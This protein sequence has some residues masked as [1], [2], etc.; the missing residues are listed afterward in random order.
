MRVTGDKELVQALRALGKGLPVSAIDSS[1]TAASKPMLDEAVENARAH[2][3]SG[4]RP[5]GG[6]VDE[7]L[8]FRKRRESTSKRRNYVIGAVNRARYILHLLE[9]GTRPHWQPRRFGGIMHPGAR[10]FPVIRPSY[11]NHADKTIER[12]GKEIWRHVMMAVARNNKSPK[13]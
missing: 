12:F 3:Q 10:P 9:F 2:R 11:E 8:V 13:R 7:G 5:K 4:A 6:H 1:M